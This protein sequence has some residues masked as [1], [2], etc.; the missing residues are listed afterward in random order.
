[1]RQKPTAKQLIDSGAFNLQLQ[2]ARTNAI[3]DT[4]LVSK[5][6]N[7]DD[8][9]LYIKPITGSLFDIIATSDAVFKELQKQLYDVTSERDTVQA[10]LDKF[11]AKNAK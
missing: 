8:N 11:K 6:F 2:E 10:E 5:Q 4:K 7:S 9:E 3:R 1:M